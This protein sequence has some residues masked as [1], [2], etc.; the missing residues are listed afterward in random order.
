MVTNK[1][2]LRLVSVNIVNSSVE[3]LFSVQDCF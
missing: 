3:N 2:V 1:I